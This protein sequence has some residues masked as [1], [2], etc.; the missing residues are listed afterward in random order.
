MRIINGVDSTVG[1]K[2]V[3][4]DIDGGTIDG[5]TIGATTAG[6]VRSKFDPDA[7]LTGTLTANQCSGG[8]ITNYGQGAA[9]TTILVPT[10]FEGGNF[11]V[12]I[13]TAQAANDY[14]VDLATGTDV[15]YLDG[16]ALSAGLGVY[17]ATPAVGNCIQFMAQQTG[18]S[19]Y[20]WFA[21]TISGPWTAQT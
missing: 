10:A 17:L 5:A 4:P 6:T 14:I 16:V 2:V 8:V 1:T 15:M 3:S 12:F 9:D 18:A 19:T 7:V 11:I 21:V 20:Q 13:S